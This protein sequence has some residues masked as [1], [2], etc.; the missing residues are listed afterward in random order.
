MKPEKRFLQETNTTEITSQNLEHYVKWLEDNCKELD[1]YLDSELIDYL[2][3]NDYEFIDEVTTEEMIESLEYK[4]YVVSESYEA[5]DEE[6]VDHNDL[7][8][9]EEIREKFLNASWAEREE[10]YNKVCR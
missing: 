3:E 8:K 5:K 10:I 1:D 4:G 7:I 6:Y 9:L 2:E